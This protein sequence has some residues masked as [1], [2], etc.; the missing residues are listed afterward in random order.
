ML[1]GSVRLRR[2][3][4][5][6]VSEKPQL[7]AA[8]VTSFLKTNFPRPIRV[9]EREVT[10]R[11]LDQS[12][13]PKQAESPPRWTHSLLS[14]CPPTEPKPVWRTVRVRPCSGATTAGKRDPNRPSLA[15]RPAPPAQL[16]PA[17]TGRAQ[18]AAGGAVQTHS[19]LTHLS[20]RWAGCAGWTGFTVRVFAVTGCGVSRSGLYVASVRVFLV[21]EGG[22]FLRGENDEHSREEKDTKR[23]AQPQRPQRPQAD[24]APPHRV[25]IFVLKT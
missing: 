20:W 4:G 12:M 9:C 21:R 15:R 7:S 1:R 6:H 11:D 25:L 10:K 2:R 14:V 3:I 16:S 18:V 22:T 24:I 17:R 13:A 8:G 19:N 23:G 5:T